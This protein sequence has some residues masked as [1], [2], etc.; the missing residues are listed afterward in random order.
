MLGTHSDTPV[1]QEGGDQSVCDF[2]M[3]QRKHMPAF[4]QF[5]VSPVRNMLSQH[6]DD[7]ANGPLCISCRDH[8]G[9]GM[10]VGPILPSRAPEYSIP[11]MAVG[12]H[13]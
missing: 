12:R 9:P 1:A 4:I 7:L 10:N 11:F 6:L 5:L 8:Q 3:D 13:G 2:R